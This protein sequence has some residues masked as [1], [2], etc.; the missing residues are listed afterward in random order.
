M[1]RPKGSKDK[2]PQHKWTDEEKEYLASIV[3]GSTYKEITK[4]MND[5]FEYNFSEEQIKGMMYRN[6]L[7]TGTGG[8]FKKGSTPWN[9]GLKGYMGANKTSFKKGTI[10]PN[11]VPIGTE[12]ITKGGY[13][14]VKV[15]EPNKWK[16]KQRY[17]YEQH[18]GEI[19]KD[20]NVIFA[21]K[22]IRNF[23]INN[24]VLVSKAEMLILNNNKLIFE[25]K[26]LTKV[27]VN[28]AKVIDKAK[29]RSK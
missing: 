15:G 14:K 12:S 13:I 23:D 27:G 10:P 28:I 11:Q 26:E 17:I 7:T 6:K 5:K 8:Y 20:C 2:K 29:K 18:Y 4:Q 24:L 3:K 16:L 22:N 21:D 9:K 1:S 19:P 25:D